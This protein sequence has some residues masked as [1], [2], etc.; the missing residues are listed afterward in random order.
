MGIPPE[1]WADHGA[2]VAQE[3]EAQ[4]QAPLLKASQRMASLESLLEGLVDLRWESRE[5]L[6][7]GLVV[8]H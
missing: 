8:L 1:V 5:S 4:I 7:G 6:L 3:F 2:K